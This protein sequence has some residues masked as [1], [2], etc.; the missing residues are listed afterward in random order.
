[1]RRRSGIGDSFRLITGTKPRNPYHEVPQ[2][3][4]AYAYDALGIQFQLDEGSGKVEGID[5]LPPTPQ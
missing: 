3:L 1:M 2:P 4:S 5:L